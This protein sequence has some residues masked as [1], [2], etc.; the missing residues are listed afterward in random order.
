MKLSWYLRRLSLMS[1]GEILSRVRDKA[2]KLAL[3]FGRR[4]F[5]RAQSR[6]LPG[7]DRP[8]RVPL[9]L[10]E[11]ELDAEL[12]QALVAA[13]EELLEGR[14]PL[15]G[16]ERRDMMPAPDWFLD[17]K[18]ASRA[19]QQ[20]FA[21]SINHRKPDEVG[22]IRH[23]WELSR[24]HHV[25]VLASAYYATGDERFATGAA[26]QLESWWGDNRFL[27]GVHWASGIELGIRLISWAWTR[28]L[29]AGWDGA[30]DLFE[31]NQTFLDQLFQHQ[32]LLARL[33][34]HG[35]SANNH[36][37]AEAAGQFVACCVF[38]HFAQTERWRRRA[39]ATLS[40]EIAHQTLASGVN[41][42]LAT[43]YHGFALELFLV[44][45]LEGEASGQPL[46]EEVWRQLRQM[47]DALAAMLDIGLRPPRQGDGD[48]SVA[49]LV[50][51]PGFARWS[52]LLATGKRLFGAC[53][54]W[55][56]ISKV[57]VRT[58]LLS[59][60]GTAPIRDESRPVRRPSMFPDAGMVILRDVERRADELWCRCDSG[61]HGYLSTASHAHADSL[62]VEVRW[63]GRD[64]LVDP[65]TYCY[66]IEADWRAYFRSTRGH[67]TI[68]LD[69]V[70]QSVAGGPFNWTRHAQSSIVRVEGLDDG[71]KAEWVG[72]HDGYAR[73][74]PPATHRRRVELDRETRVVSIEDHVASA[75]LHECLLAFHLG[76]DVRCDLEGTTAELSWP[77]SR[78]SDGS[79]A[80]LRLPEA[81]DWECVRG[82][83]D[84]PAGWY[85]P[86]FDIKVP[87]A[88]LFG[89]GSIEGETRFV[90]RLEFEAVRDDDP[91]DLQRS[92]SGS[93]AAV[94]K[95]RQR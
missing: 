83:S 47:T 81:L 7:T 38:P 45:A 2:V 84:P 5:A 86:S 9:G 58:E 76:P 29:L 49:L 48:D 20:R 13:A 32:Y 61:P 4:R 17:T 63:G 56:E 67:N 66:H 60:L 95:P 77:E 91:A 36:L 69:G 74:D 31:H 8:A 15:F 23:L 21:Y 72:T 51:A 40:A 42:E 68:E 70:D 93:A 35:S 53:D 87:A 85:S 19:P 3:R 73:L 64:I 80:V 12:T 26:R 55:P 33:P 54:W 39:V 10:D 92:A 6:L 90:T 43:D 28:R 50:D 24:H 27:R 22:S 94:Q 30:A 89:R 75:G 1:P 52:S 88:A 59:A 71:P 78:G 79:G 65:G 18:T 82:Q 11:V 57:D 41:R 46:G 25:T 34:S 16:T 62:S 44:A 37:I 14:W